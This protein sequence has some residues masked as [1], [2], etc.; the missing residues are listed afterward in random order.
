ML[1]A[2]YLIKTRHELLL[3]RY[4][5]KKN[6]FKRS[7][8]SVSFRGP[9]KFK[10]S[11][12]WLLVENTFGRDTATYVRRR[13]ESWNSADFRPA[14]YFPHAHQELAKW[15]D[16]FLIFWETWLEDGYLTSSFLQSLVFISHR[17]LL[18]TL[19]FFGPK[20]TH[21]SLLHIWLPLL[22]GQS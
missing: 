14:S 16:R 3:F 4:W 6:E 10:V 22:D 2:T 13:R 8:L 9:W 5:A 21:T 15:P 1:I 11:A 17:V 18:C 12:A 7:L 19:F 20:S